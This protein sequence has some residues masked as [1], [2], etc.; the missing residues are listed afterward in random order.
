MTAILQELDRISTDPVSAEELDRARA[1][2]RGRLELRM[3][4]S[5]AVAGWIGTGE[6]LLP[7]ILTVNEVIEHLEAV[8]VD[9]LL[10][11]AR[12]FLAPS[13]ARLAVLGPFR[14]RARFERALRS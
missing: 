11:V 14:S 1:Y 3:E 2:T 7:R 12:R 8:T 5:G 9:D 6:T 4:D 13:E 10:R